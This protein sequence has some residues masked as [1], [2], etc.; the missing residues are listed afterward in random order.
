MID[1]NTIKIPQINP[2]EYLHTIEERTFLKYSKKM[3][4]YS[5]DDLK[6]GSDIVIF[7][8]IRN[9][10]SR[11]YEMAESEVVAVIDNRVLTYKC[12]FPG[13]KEKRNNRLLFLED[14]KHSWYFLNNNDI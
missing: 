11:V 7:R 5:V 4:K 13:H 2:E 6:S 3:H 8:C 12:A 10:E 1:I 14:Y 9:G